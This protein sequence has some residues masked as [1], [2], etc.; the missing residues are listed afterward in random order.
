MF[1]LISVR[2]LYLYWQHNVAIYYVGT[3]RVLTHTLSRADSPCDG[4]ERADDR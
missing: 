3:H 4:F 1:G 2:S